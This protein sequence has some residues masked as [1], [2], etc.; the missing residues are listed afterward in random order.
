MNRKYVAI[1]YVLSK[2]H[3]AIGRIQEWQG[4]S[5][6]AVIYSNYNYIV[7]CDQKLWY[8]AKAKN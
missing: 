1:L 2:K 4:Q 5:E 8:Q 3:I 6:V 7:T